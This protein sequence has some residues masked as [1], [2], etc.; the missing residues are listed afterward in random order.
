AQ[1]LLEREREKAP[2]VEAILT[3]QN[4]DVAMVEG[5]LAILRS[6]VFLRRV[7][8]REHLAQR[9]SGTAS[10]EPQPEDGRIFDYIRSLLPNLVE[11]PTKP[12]QKQYPQNEDEA[13]EIAAIEALNGSLSVSRA[14]QYG[15]VLGIS[16]TSPDPAKAARLA[17]AVAETYLLDKLDTRFEAAKKA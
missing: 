8:Q 4:P 7:V 10:S 17:N 3:A 16:V 1:V 13:T 6:S 2:G 11:Q 5:E 14:A 9:S 12:T 15:F